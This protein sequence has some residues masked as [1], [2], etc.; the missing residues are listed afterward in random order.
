MAYIDFKARSTSNNHTAP[1]VSQEGIKLVAS[2]E[3]LLASWGH[4]TKIILA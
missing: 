1:A 3:E 2:N 4:Q